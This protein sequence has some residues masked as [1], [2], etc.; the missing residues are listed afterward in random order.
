MSTSETITRTDL[1]NILNEVLPASS[2][3]IGTYGSTTYAEV[4]AADN[5]GKLIVFKKFD[6]QGYWNLFHL[7]QKSSDRFTFERMRANTGY[8]ELQTF[9]LL[10]DDTYNLMVGRSLVDSRGIASSNTF[11]VSLGAYY[12]SG[13]LTSDAGNLNLSFPTGRVFPSGTTLNKVTFDIVARAG[14]ANASGMYVV[15][16]TS[17]G[18]DL[19]PFDSSSAFSFYNGANASKSLAANKITVTLQGLTNINVSMAS[20]SQHFFSG[21]ATNSGYVNNQPVAMI[22][23][24]I[25]VNVTLP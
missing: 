17:G 5:A 10:N 1:T 15:K 19:A 8:S 13:F 11:A 12:A 18:S 6:N 22:L 16:K 7:I 23:N 14:N 20:G 21:S 2:I 25:T 4:Q 24:N 3:F 9:D